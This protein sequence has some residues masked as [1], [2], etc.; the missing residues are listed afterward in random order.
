[1]MDNLRNINKNS[2]KCIEVNNTKEERILSQKLDGNFVLV[3]LDSDNYK[4]ILSLNKLID[5]FS[6]FRRKSILKSFNRKKMSS[7]S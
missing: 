4:T 1:M 5:S 7:V 3:K 6:Y 2:A